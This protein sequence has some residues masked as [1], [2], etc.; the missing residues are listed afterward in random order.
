[1]E[2]MLNLPVPITEEDQLEVDDG[3]DGESGNLVSSQ[4][5]RDLIEGAKV[6]R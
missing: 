5:M 2:G 1:M 3:S 6:S 4:E